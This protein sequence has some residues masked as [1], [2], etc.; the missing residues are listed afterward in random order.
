MQE[1]FG[2]EGHGVSSAVFA[3]A[4]GEGDVVAVIGQDAFG[5]KGG[6]INIGGEVFEGGFAAAHGLNIGHPIHRPNTFGDLA[7]EFGMILLQGLFEASAKTESQNSLGQKMVGVFRTDPT[8]TI[9]GKTTGGDDTV[10]VRMETEVAGPGLKHREQAQFCAQIFMFATDIQKSRGTM[11]DQE[12]VESLLVG[13][14]QGAQLCGDGESDQVVWDR[15]KA[16]ALAGEPFGG[17]GMS[18]LGAGAMVAGVISKVLPSALAPIELTSEGGSAAAENGSDG[19]PVRGQQARTKLPF[20][21]RP[22]AA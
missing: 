21:R 4:I 12:W 6:A 5:A 9:G 3:V 16:A 19:A 20:I 1:P 15:Q 14:D 22:V 8:Q 13:T 7:E 18:A 17:I 10:D 11:A 2:G